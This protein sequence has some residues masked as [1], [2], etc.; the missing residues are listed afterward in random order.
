[1]RS[2]FGKQIALLAIIG[3]LTIGLAISQAAGQGSDGEL[4]IVPS[5]NPAKLVDAPGKDKLEANCLVCHQAQPILTH[6]GFTPEVWSA[7]VQKMRNTYGAEISDEDAAWI[8]AYL[9]DNYSSE[10]VS[11]ENVL[12][13]GSNATWGSEPVFQ[14]GG[15]PA[16][17][18]AD[19]PPE[20]TPEA[21]PS[22]G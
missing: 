17:P 19:G 7:E 1:M 10:P 20:V 8:I 4:T 11:P 21:S 22:E 9:T 2:T 5:Q 13:N 18:Q 16:T 3:V 6:A 12:L 14:Q 15:A